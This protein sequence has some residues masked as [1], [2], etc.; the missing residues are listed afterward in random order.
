MAPGVQRALPAPMAPTVVEA[1]AVAVRPAMA[2]WA[3][4]AALVLTSLGA[5]S[6]AAGVAAAVA[7]VHR[8]GM[9]IQQAAPEASTV[10]AEAAHHR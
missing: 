2:Q 3:A 1:V 10:V 9:Q 5:L 4:Q 7:T 6:E 8:L